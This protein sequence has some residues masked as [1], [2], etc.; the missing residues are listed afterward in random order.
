MF[1]FVICF[2][3]VVVGFSLSISSLSVSGKIVPTRYLWVGNIPLDMK[4]R[5]LEHAFARYG[6]IKT[7]DYANGDPTAIVT[8]G[9]S[10][11]AVKARTKLVG[12]LQL[13]DG[14]V[15]RHEGNVSPSSRRGKQEHHSTGQ[16]EKSLGSLLGFR[17][18]YLDRPTTRRFVIVRPQYATTARQ[19]SPSPSAHSQ[20]RES[21]VASSAR[22]S[23]ESQRSRSPSSEA[24]HTEKEETPFTESLKTEAHSPSP[25]PPPLVAI[26]Q[27]RSTERSLSP[28]PADLSPIAGRS[29][30]EPIGSYL[31]PKDT[32]NVHNISSLMSLCEELNLSATQN[33][34]ALS[35]V[36]PVQFILKSHAYDA[37]MHFLAGSPTLASVLLGQPGDLVAAKTE[38][39]ITQRLR[40]DQHKLDDLERNLRASVTTAMSNLNGHLSASSISLP[41]RKPPTA[42]N[43]TKFV[44]LISSPKT[45][46]S[47]RSTRELIK[48]EAATPPHG[49]LPNGNDTTVEFKK[50][51]IDNH[52]DNSDEEDETSLSRLISYLATYVS[53]Y[54]FIRHSQGSRHHLVWFFRK[55]A[56]GVISI[57]FYPTPLNG[58]MHTSKQELAVLHIFP[59]CGFTQ[60]ILKFICPSIRFGSGASP[61][62]TTRA[63]KD[64]HLMLIIVH[65]D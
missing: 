65:N 39:K 12:T 58:H 62:R 49:L 1:S 13:I 18:D 17:F 45:L 41:G 5:D 54:R 47:S 20:S 22:S 28:P 21:S 7:L 14:Q 63:V 56:A 60:S 3:V 6:Q 38:L 36:Y 29:F 26:K 25:T 59:P 19:A 32:A 52:D 27:R 44:I 64:E 9:D 61:S 48:S 10:E 51:K 34:T 2:V 8:Y 37:R 23:V 43:Q 53:A 24:E 40:L 33:S 57:P 31:S 55:E 4:R 50:E 42:A 15:I 16:R 35:T 30:Y 11:D 46:S